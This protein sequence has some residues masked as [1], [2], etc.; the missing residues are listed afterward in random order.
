MVVAVGLFVAGTKCYSLVPGGGI[1]GFTTM[2]SSV[3][4][5]AKSG[6]G[7]RA[8]V[9]LLGWLSM[10]LFFV[11]TI[12]AT[13]APAGMEP[14]ATVANVTLAGPFPNYLEEACGMPGARHLLDVASVRRLHGGAVESGAP[15]ARAVLSH[16][17][18]FLGCLSC[19]CLVLAHRNNRWIQPLPAKRM[20]AFTVEEVRSGFAAVPLII[21]ANLASNMA[22]NAMNNAF[23]SQACQMNTM[24]GGSQ[25]N[26]A[27]FTLADAIAVVVL[28]PV[29]ESVVYPLVQ[30]AKG[31]PVRVG[32][33]LIAGLLIVACANGVAAW[34][35]VSRRHAPLMCRDAMSEC[36]PN[37]IHM[38][39]MSAFWMFIPF[40]LIGASEILVNPCMY[41]FAYVAA[42][43]KVRSLVQAF[44][45]F[46]QGSVSNA[47]TAVAMSIAFPDD[48]DTGNLDVYYFINILCVLSGVVLYFYLTRCGSN[49]EDIETDVR[50]EEMDPTEHVWESSISSSAEG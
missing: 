33:K 36:A 28:T 14:E 30:R 10:P 11:C 46:F 42:P 8:Y 17:A 47:F 39:D 22:Y 41:Y 34:L 1:E 24:L 35:E 38:R 26:G 16:A 2:V 48:L 37:G 9:A 29:F 32:Q 4:H 23:P 6:G 3:A 21:V 13:L 19:I 49:M 50:D 40:G 27:F 44:N 43:P 45:L 25:L 12:A 18:L 7:V 5:S 20:T 15:G 31:S